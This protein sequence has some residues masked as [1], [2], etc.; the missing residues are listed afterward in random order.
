MAALRLDCNS[1]RCTL[2]CRSVQ[3]IHPA[4]QD[5]A[6]PRHHGG[7]AHLSS[8]AAL[9]SLASDQ[10]RAVQNF[11]TYR[12]AATVQLIMFFFIALF[13]F[14]PREFQP[15]LCGPDATPDALDPNPCVKREPAGEAGQENFE[16]VRLGQVLLFGLG[17][18]LAVNPQHVR[19]HRVVASRRGGAREVWR[20]VLWECLKDTQKIPGQQKKQPDRR[21]VFVYMA[22]DAPCGVRAQQLAV[23][24]PASLHPCRVSAASVSGT[25]CCVAN[26]LLQFGH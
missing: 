5:F 26:R 21:S 16:E 23:H 1:S 8:T 3:I 6:L 24:Q 15:P 12:I 7:T 20:G 25:C 13:A 11:L 14:P 4:V 2:H 17:G 19:M 22:L 18:E 10:A 9:L